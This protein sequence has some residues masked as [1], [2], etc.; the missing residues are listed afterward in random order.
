MPR[1][2]LFAPNA[3]E[4]SDSCSMHERFDLETIRCF[5]LGRGSFA[6]SFVR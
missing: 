2:D 1:A 6:T 5:E 4:Y 3:A